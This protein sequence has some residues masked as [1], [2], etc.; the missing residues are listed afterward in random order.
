MNKQETAQILSYIKVA[1]PAYAAK[2]TQED[3]AMAINLWHSM[4]ADDDI[5]DVGGAVKAYICTD[6]SGF[7]PSIA[8]IKDMLRKLRADEQE[9]TAG[10]AW[11]LVSRAAEDGYYNSKKEFDKLP[12][13]VQQALGGCH[14]ILRDYSQMDIRT[15]ETII[16]SQFT[17]EYN[18]ILDREKEMMM[19]PPQV[20][21]Y[22]RGLKES[23]ATKMVQI[24]EG[25]R[26]T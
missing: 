15:F 11:E 5:R 25:E 2:M 24:E 6:T 21:E 19:L 8:Q 20:K 7:A 16:R 4:F 26:K 3:A 17:K 1:Y 14:K 10:E 23:T 18:T 12:K 13:I 22:F 9:L